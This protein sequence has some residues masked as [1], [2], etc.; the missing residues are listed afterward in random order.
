MGRFENSIALAKASWRVLRD[1]KQLTVLPLLSGL[2]TL[3]VAAT[4]LIPVA[5][6]AHDGTSGGYSGSPAVWILGA[7]G[8][9]V[10]AF[11]VIYFNAALVY[12][13]DRRL[14]GDDTSIGSALSFASSRAHVLLPWAVV[15]ASV[16]IVMRMIEE[17]GGLI[18]RIIGA[19][20]GI[21]WSLVTFLVLPVLVVEGLGPIA[22]VKRSGELFKRTWGEQMISNAG[23]GILAMLAIVAGLIPAL[24]L[25]A[26]GGPLAVVAT[27]I[28][29]VWV[30]AVSIV[31]ST[32]TGILQTALYR[33][34]TEGQVPGFDTSG[35]HGA[36]R[37][38]NRRG[39]FN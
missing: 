29:V 37:P 5:L 17:R 12:A 35:L 13:A 32:L 10:T 23:I 24:L 21:A 27:V 38:R 18:G 3:L 2:A 9:F 30:V 26:V 11:V 19:I 8:Y 22:A 15:S 16:S 20:G 7:L 1:D 39:F 4:F 31:A 28:F 36:F 33:Y 14:R 25:G 6:V 34:A